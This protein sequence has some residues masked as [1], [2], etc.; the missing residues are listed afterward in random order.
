MSPQRDSSIET[1][2]P[3]LLRALAKRFGSGSDEVDDRTVAG[4]LAYHALIEIRSK[5]RRPGPSTDE[6][7]ESIAYLADLTHNLPLGP[8][9]R[10]SRVQPAGRRERALRD[11]PMS[12]T[13]NTAEEPGRSPF[14]GG[15]GS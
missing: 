10:P 15:R 8:G 3:A 14:P 7:L 6:A 12:W 4:L 13:W 9:P 2:R 11:R 5:A 1:P